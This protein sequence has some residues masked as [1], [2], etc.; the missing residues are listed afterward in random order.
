MDYAAIIEHGH[1]TVA[2]A[3]RSDPIMETAHLID[4]L[5]PAVPHPAV[6]VV[7]PR[8]EDVGLGGQAEHQVGVQLVPRDS[9]LVIGYQFGVGFA[10]HRQDAAAQ[11]LQV[12]DLVFEV[13]ERDPLVGD[14]SSAL[15]QVFE[16]VC[17]VGGGGE[18]GVGE[19]EGVGLQ[20]VDVEGQVVLEDV[21]CLLHLVLA[22]QPLDVEGEVI[23]QKLLL[24]LVVLALLQNLRDVLV[25]GPGLVDFGLQAEHVCR[26][27][28][29]QTTQHFAYI[30]R[31]RHKHR[32][33]SILRSC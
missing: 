28:Q 31:L 4:H 20:V 1:L 17:E 3:N 22:D 25:Y 2:E 16:H 12:P 14:E 8:R 13:E 23:V 30:G 26:L 9:H 24:V 32:T 21:E 10:V 29:A 33:I 7:S 5:E 27:R 19:E 18:V 15:D 11:V 6:G